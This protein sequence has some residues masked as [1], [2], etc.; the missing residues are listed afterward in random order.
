MQNF[1]DS[2]DLVGGIPEEGLREVP[3]QE[4][5]SMLEEARKYVPAAAVRGV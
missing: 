2:G 4:L 5:L 1:T 3:K